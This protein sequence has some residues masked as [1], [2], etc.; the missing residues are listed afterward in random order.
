ML[1]IYKSKNHRE[2]KGEEIKYLVLHYTAVPESTTFGIFTNNPELT[3]VDAEYFA[4]SST[5]PV[6]LCKNEVSAHYVN[7]EDGTVYSIVDEKQAA[8]H[9]GVSF[10]NGTKNINNSSIGIEQV[11]LGFNWLSKFPQERGK[12]VPGTPEMWC[13]YTDAQIDATIKLCQAIIQRHNIQPY[14]V[15]GHSDIAC[16]RKADPGPLFPWKKL[17]DAGVGIWYDVNES[18]LTDVPDVTW[19]QTKLAEYGYECAVTGEYNDQ[20]KNTVRAL[21]MHFRPTNVDG[22]ID[23]ESAQILDSLCQRK[24]KLQQRSGNLLRQYLPSF[25]NDYMFI[26]AVVIVGVVAAGISL[27]A[28]L[29]P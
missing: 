18:S 4:G 3:T 19:M 9:A 21:Q 7:T 17:A 26:A 2:R 12:V 10:W 23:L 25:S 15:V 27:A 24:Q 28:K 13:A 20:T 14:N 5:D 22:I 8:Y 1:H 11:N 29:R 6:A 16:G